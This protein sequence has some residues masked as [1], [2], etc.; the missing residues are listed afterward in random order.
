MKTTTRTNP[1]PSRHQYPF[2]ERGGWIEFYVGGK[3]I[4]R[5]DI[6][7]HYKDTKYP[8][9]YV[10]PAFTA[11]SSSLEIY[12]NRHRGHGIGREIIEHIENTAEENGMARVWFINVRN[13]GFVEKMGYKYTG[14]G[15]IYEKVL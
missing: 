5:T 7:F 12:E 13:I 8:F 11:L 2:S 6:A 9:G 3:E 4:G 14:I 10:V 1:F 15:S